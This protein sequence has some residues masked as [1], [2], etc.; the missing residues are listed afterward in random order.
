MPWR[1]LATVFFAIV[2]LAGVMTYRMLRTDTQYAPG[3]SDAKWAQIRVG[4]SESVVLQLLG[5]PLQ[6]RTFARDET[7]LYAAGDDCSHQAGRVLSFRSNKVQF[8]WNAPDSVLDEDPVAVRQSLGEPVRI[9]RAMSGVGWLYT[10]QANNSNYHYRELIMFEGRVR[11]I[12]A[13]VYYD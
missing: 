1:K 2:G 8:V 10:Q 12:T 13:H 9:C 3:Y 11:E 7:W 4:N 6:R 5:S